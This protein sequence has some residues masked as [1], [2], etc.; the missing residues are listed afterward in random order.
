[1]LHAQGTPAHLRRKTAG[2]TLALRAGRQTARSDVRLARV[3]SEQLSET[4]T[5]VAEEISGRGMALK[6]GVVEFWA[7][8]R[9]VP[10][11]HDSIVLLR[12]PC[13]SAQKFG[14]SRC[15]PA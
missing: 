2:E 7:C 15:S 14:T 4:K 10:P 9:D 12:T 11:L 1:M 8:C 13:R 5:N 6:N 3:Q